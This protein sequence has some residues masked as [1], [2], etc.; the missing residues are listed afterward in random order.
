[1]SS[2]LFIASDYKPR[3]GGIAAYIDGLARGLIS[4]GHDVKVLAVV[5]PD[6]KERIAFLQKYE[7]WVVP[8]E[9]VHDE[10]PEGWFADKFVSLLEIARCWSVD[11][12][13][14]VEKTRFFRNSCDAITRLER[15]LGSENPATVVFGHLDE[16]L[17]P[18]AL[19]L[20]GR[21]IPYGVIGH[22]FE[23][24][25]LP[26]LINDGVRRG[27]MLRGATW[28]AANSRHTKRLLQMWGI[29]ERKIMI[30]HPPVSGAVLDA[31]ISAPLVP[32]RDV[33]NLLT[34][35]RLVKTKGVDIVLSALKRL[36]DEGVPF[37]YV[38]AGE[39]PER[40]EL[41]RLTHEYGLDG[42][43]HFA[44]YI[45][46]QQ[47]CSLL[48]FSDVFVMPSR[49]NPRKSHEGFGIVFME[50]AAF[51]VPSVGSKAGGIPDAILDGETGMLVP[52]ESPEGLARALTC[53][54]RQADK[55]RSMG[56]AAMQRARSAFSPAVI[57]A[58]FEREM[59]LRLPPLSAP[60]P[61]TSTPFWSRATTVKNEKLE[62]SVL[63][64]PRCD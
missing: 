6:E 51:A 2:I 28:L 46:E 47:K 63:T 15:V 59:A 45:T 23:V 7:P 35:C 34:I 10:R 9:V 36:N 13:R 14:R 61:Q 32:E 1:M 21:K 24:F 20:Q 55:R 18:L 42:K 5:H 53:L 43:V 60:V 38:V 64:R 41:E 26:H 58:T 17:Y 12:R 31:A 52:P 3:T 57:A 33:F 25:R 49:V 27:S 37:H 4:L 30:L 44:G 19:Y 16:R 54:Y 56:K 22:D 40:A 39:G 8:F 62:E 11:T 48:G 50:A 29:P